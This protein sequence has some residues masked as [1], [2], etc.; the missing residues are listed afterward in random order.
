MKDR[1]MKPQGKTQVNQIY[2]KEIKLKNPLVHM[3]RRIFF[4]INYLIEYTNFYY[5]YKK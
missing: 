5:L 3:S 4:K 2:K 1:R